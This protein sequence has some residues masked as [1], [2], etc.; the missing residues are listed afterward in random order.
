MAKLRKKTTNRADLFDNAA[1][2]GRASSY[3][4]WDAAFAW[5]GRMRSGG[6][7]VTAAARCDKEW[8]KFAESVTSWQLLVA[9]FV[10]EESVEEDSS[11]DNFAHDS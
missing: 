6:E 10:T 11:E 9:A 3:H 4:N 2:P 1:M 7:E 5:W 8:Y